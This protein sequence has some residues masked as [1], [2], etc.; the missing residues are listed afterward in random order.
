MNKPSRRDVRQKC[1]EARYFEYDSFHDRLFV[2]P[3]MILIW[4][5]VRIGVS[6]NTVSW[7][8]GAFA[9]AGA[10]ALSVENPYIVLFGSFGYLVFYLLD[11]VDGGVARYRDE[12]GMSGQYVDWIIHVI[13]AVATM[14]G[15]LGGAL[16]N[17]G[18]WIF[19]FG[20]LAITASALTTARYSMGWFAVCME[21]QQRLAKGTDLTHEN[22][23]KP[24]P[25]SLIYRAF[26]AGSTLLFHENYLIFTL[27]LLAFAQLFTPHVFPDFRIIMVLMGGTVYFLVM[28]FDISRIAK[29]RGIDQAYRKLFLDDT[30]P[31]LPDDHFF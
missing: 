9:L 31:N 14:A 12:A 6:G 13:A 2:P 29:E 3:A 15:L 8:S 25:P 18:F 20:I 10:F 5:F 22:S 1:I 23:Q 11:Y 17:I 26:R 24:I 19:P 30:K 28:V 27:P 7:I 21:R 16:H 4:V